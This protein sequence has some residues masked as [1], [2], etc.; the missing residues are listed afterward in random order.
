MGDV[1]RG[2]SGRSLAAKLAVLVT[3]DENPIPIGLGP[4]LKGI[5]TLT[6]QDGAADLA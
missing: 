5:E 1:R 3:D 4:D 6:H 2:P